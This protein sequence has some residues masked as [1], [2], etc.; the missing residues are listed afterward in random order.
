MTNLA[1]LNVRS[2]EPAEANAVLDVLNEAAGWLSQ[3]RIRQWPSSFQREWLEP[4]LSDGRVLLGRLNGT[5][6]ATATLA[7]TDPLWPDDHSA[8]YLHFFAVRRAAAGL[9]A[10]LLAWVTTAVQEHGRRLLRLDCPA[11]NTP[12][13]TYYERVGF[14]HVCDVQLPRAAALWSP[15]GTLL[16]LYERYLNDLSA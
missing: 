14:R 11:D 3:R 7:W 5:I 4:A 13:R 1:R 16:S 6:V 8:G 9:G 10:E 12:L 2:A 15:P